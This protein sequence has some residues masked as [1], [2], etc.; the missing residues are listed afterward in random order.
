MQQVQLC[1]V[2]AMAKNRVIGRENEL[3]WRLP[4]DLARFQGITMGHPIIMGRKTFESIGRP[5]RGRTS[6]VVTRQPQ[7]SVEGVIVVHSLDEAYDAAAKQARADGLQ[8]IMLIGGAELFEQG[9][10]H[11]DRIYLTEVEAEVDGD[12]FFPKITLSDW[13][14][15]TEDTW[16]ADENNEFACSFK[17]LERRNKGVD[18]NN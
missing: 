7:W 3:P 2:V 5:L 16:P 12:T 15:T 18:D 1:L 6:I 13:Q 11:S 14:V 10:S 4:E 17:V 9:M 8:E